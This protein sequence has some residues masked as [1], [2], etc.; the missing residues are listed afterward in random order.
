[1]GP[2]F[3]LPQKINSSSSFRI[4]SPPKIPIIADFGLT[5][6]SSCAL[7]VARGGLHRIERRR[8]PRPSP[9]NGRS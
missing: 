6:S 9:A 7:V 2:T 4:D 1:M 8:I 5:T 3:L